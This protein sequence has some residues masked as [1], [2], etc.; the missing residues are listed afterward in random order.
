MSWSFEM[1]Q[2]LAKDRINQMLREVERDR[3][4]K[5]AATS[6]SCD[7]A[8]AGPLSSAG[9]AEPLSPLRSRDRLTLGVR[10]TH[11]LP[12]FHQSDGGEE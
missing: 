2:L 3:L 11:P 10:H 4:A 12:G 7:T 5:Q 8:S 9:R 6:P 1:T